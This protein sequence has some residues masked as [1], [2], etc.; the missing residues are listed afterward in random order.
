MPPGFLGSLTQA[1]DKHAIFDADGAATGLQL[2]LPTIAAHGLSPD[3]RGQVWP[4]LLGL[5]SPSTSLA[6]QNAIRYGWLYCT[7]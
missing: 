6:E 2:A 4:V 3:L 1:A 7:G 5:Y